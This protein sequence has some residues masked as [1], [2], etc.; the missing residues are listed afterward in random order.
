[1]AYNLNATEMVYDFIVEK[2]RSNEWPPGSRIWSEAELCRETGVSRTA[3]RQAVEKL[4]ALSVLSKVHGSGTFVMSAQTSSLS[5]MPFFQLEQQDILALLEFRQYFEVGNVQ[6]YIE[7]ADENDI[8]SLEQ[9][10]IEM[11][12]NRHNQETFFQLDNEF[13]NMIAEGSKNTYSIKV[14]DAFLEAMASAQWGLYVN[15]GPDIGVEYHK[16][17]LEHIKNRDK[18][19]ASIFMKRHMEANIMALRQKMNHSPQEV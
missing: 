13:H 7:R 11:C 18:E 10:Y 12:E 19:L 8:A 3:V 2:I 17:I 14:A 4:S 15:L 1:M 9:N 5:G 16:V 6:M